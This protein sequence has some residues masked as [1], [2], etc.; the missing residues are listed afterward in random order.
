MSGGHVDVTELVARES[1]RD[2][3]ARYNSLGDRG[4]IDDV[5]ALFDAEGVLVFRDAQGER[6]FVGPAQI[7]DLMRS[8][9]A[10]W[11]AASDAAARYVRHSIG[12]HVIDVAGEDRASGSCYVTVLR[13]GGLAEWGRYRDEY[14][15]V[16]G[17]W[18]FARRLAIRDGVA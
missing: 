16:N 9:A 17:K 2:L 11:A 14:V 3:V 10:D 8:V 13:A 5:A 12:T 7:A 15:R 18:L 4:R 6:T 1:I